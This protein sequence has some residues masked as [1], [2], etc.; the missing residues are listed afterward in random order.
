MK[1]YHDIKN[2]LQKNN[3]NYYQ[4]IDKHKIIIKYII[5]GCTAALTDLVLLYILTEFFHLWYLLSASF[6]FLIAFFVSFYLQKFWTFRD[7]NR[8]RIYKQMSL[9]FIVAVLNL[10]I[11]AIGMY[12]IVEKF[13][14]MYILAQIIM[15]K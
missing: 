3:P 11:N 7:E 9:Y 5:S 15:G 2:R 1:L 4:K 14:I 6:A 13:N 8:D 10:G 12:I